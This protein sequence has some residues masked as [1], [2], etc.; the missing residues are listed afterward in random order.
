MTHWQ[1]VHLR[2]SSTL[3]VHTHYAPT[4]PENR[5]DIGFGERNNKRAVI[6]NGKRYEALSAAGRALGVTR[7]NISYWLRIGKAR[8][9]E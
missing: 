8:Y 2:L 7:Q 4:P 1:E 5:G 3:P 6:V 9:A